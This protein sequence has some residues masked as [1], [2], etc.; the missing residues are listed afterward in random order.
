MVLYPSGE[1]RLWLNSAKTRATEDMGLVN[2]ARREPTVSALKDQ[3]AV[4]TGASGSIGA[5]IARALADRGV[6]LCLVQHVCVPSLSGDQPPGYSGDISVCEADLG[7]DDDIRRLVATVNRD[8]GG[9]DILVH[10][11]GVISAGQVLRRRRSS[12]WTTSTES[13]FGPPTSCRRRFCQVCGTEAGR[14]CS[15]TQARV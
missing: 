10:S 4:V 6:R 1:E 11:A 3:V 9:C 7:I 14:S 13:M 15:S 8:H 5:A 12:H 2:C